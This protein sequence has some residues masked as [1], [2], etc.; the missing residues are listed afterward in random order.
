[1]HALVVYESMFGNTH[2][3]AEEIAAGIAATGEMTAEVTSV[4]GADAARVA[5]CDLLVVGGPT[6]VHGMTSVASRRG[7][8]E[9]AEKD[10]DV[11]LDDHAGD[12][13]LRDWFEALGDRRGR[14]AAAFDTRIDAP[15]LVT[16]RASKGIAKRLRHHGMDLVVDPESFL[17]DKE[18]H[19]LDDQAAHAR[20]WGERLATAM[21]TLSRSPSGR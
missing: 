1:V 16:G 17:V 14:H 19:L 6:H 18:N 20:S 4:D 11:E 5:A 21:A 13:G 9:Q 7:A 10:P 2:R 8:A 15:P 3:I 12:E